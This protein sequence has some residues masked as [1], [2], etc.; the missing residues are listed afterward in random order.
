MKMLWSTVEL[1]EVCTFEN[2]DRGENY[3][4][5]SVQTN[6][7]VPFI[8]AG[9]LTANG[10]D[11]QN[12]NFI[13]RERFDLLMK[14]KIRPNDILFCLRGS[15]GKF[16]SVGELT[17]GAIASSLVIVRPRDDL[18]L[19]EYLLAYFSSEQ[20]TKMIDYY[21]NG[22]AQ[23]NLSAQSL[24]KFLIPIPP[25]SEQR[26]IVAILDEAFAGL[27]MMRV[28]AE[29][30]LLN[31][32]DIFSNLCDKIF[33]ETKLK[34]NE[35]ALD[36]TCIVER[37]SSPRPIKKYITSNTDGVNWVKIGD[38]VEGDKY[39][40]KTARKITSEGAKKSRYVKEGD[41]I[42]SN[43]MSFGRPYIMK[44]NG[45]I[46]DGWFVLRL[47]NTI[48][49]DYFYYLLS[50]A[51]VQSQFSKLA[52]GAIVLNISS[53]LVKK[54]MLPVPPIE[55][56]KIIAKKLDILSEEIDKIT[57]IYEQKCTKISE[58]REAI[59][60]S[61]FSGELTSSEIAA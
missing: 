49:S 4:S 11:M 31:S 9:H 25:L 41:F 37:G 55:H 20:C 18:I 29:K 3:P 19:P 43:S 27:E 30:N 42:L 13:P 56:Q 36:V 60:R 35:K 22:A 7:G 2:G 50:S 40:Y 54:A 51:Y 34:F 21:R 46:H 38:A 39:I 14:G 8:N 24:K 53:D 61:A 47:N 10:I 28:N 23:P 32:R 26:R 45:Y 48:N 5:R 58:L 1:K 57:D 33:E 59:L 6:I 44:T 16:A 12:M 17:E 15:L 52:S